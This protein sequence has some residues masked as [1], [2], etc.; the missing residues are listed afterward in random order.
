MTVVSRGIAA[1]GIP[2]SQIYFTTKYMSSRSVQPVDE[3]YSVLRHSLKEL[4]KGDLG[5]AVKKEDVKEEGG[6]S[7][8]EGGKY[9]DLMLIHAPFG[10]EKGRKNNWEALKRAQEEGWIKDI[11]VSNL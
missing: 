7:N 4:Y 6:V 2:R 11:G 3:V 5:E 1:S 9:I 10:G 8:G